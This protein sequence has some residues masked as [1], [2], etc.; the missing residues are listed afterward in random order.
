M[1]PWVRFRA[2]AIYPA[3]H[4][5][6]QI[7]V[8]LLP[9]CLTNSRFLF[10]PQ[11]MCLPSCV[12]CP[13]P[14]PP[15]PGPL[16]HLTLNSAGGV[17][18]TEDSGVGAAGIAGLTAAGAMFAVAGVVATRRY[19]GKRSKV[20]RGSQLMDPVLDYEMGESSS[21]LSGGEATV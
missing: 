19:G 7:Q 9:P 4:E 1:R 20:L 18:R 21:D 17:G 12:A 11:S 14:R 5:C 16:Q 2:A 13:P 3:R 8:H 6:N 15:S 10:R